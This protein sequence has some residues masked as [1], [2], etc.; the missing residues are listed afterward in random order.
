MVSLSFNACFWRERGGLAVHG[1]KWVAL[2]YLSVGGRDLARDCGNLTKGNDSAI[3]SK[4]LRNRRLGT[5][6]GREVPSGSSRCRPPVDV[7]IESARHPVRVP[8]PIEPNRSG[9][10]APSRERLALTEGEP[11]D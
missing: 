1:Y 5:G 3:P 9:P 8:P 11:K 4:R 10:G 6:T 2:V 7:P